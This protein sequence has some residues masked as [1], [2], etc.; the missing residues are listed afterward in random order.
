[1]DL[2]GL[3]GFNVAFDFTDVPTL[4]LKPTAI[5]AD[6]DKPNLNGRFII[7]QPDGI[8]TTIYYSALNWNGVDYNSCSEILRLGC[9]DTYTKGTYTIIFFAQCAGYTATQFARFWDM[10]YK[11]I[12]QKLESVFDCFTPS[13]QYKDNT[14]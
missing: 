11:P 10:E 6:A 1:M 4:V 5:I 8:T 14:I 2:N 12:V 9:D 3:V 7:T 13:L